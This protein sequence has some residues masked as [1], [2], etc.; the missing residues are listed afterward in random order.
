MNPTAKNVD[1]EY[2]A[3]LC[4]VFEK[5]GFHISLQVQSATQDWPGAFDQGRV[6]GATAED[7]EVM[8]KDDRYEKDDNA[9]NEF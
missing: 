7:E 3:I 8:D 6:I 4:S 5:E 2:S 1:W 9:H